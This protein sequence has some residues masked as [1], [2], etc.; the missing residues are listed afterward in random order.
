MSPT[1]KL[2]EE[3]VTRLAQWKKMLSRQRVMKKLPDEETAHTIQMLS[4]GTGIVSFRKNMKP[5]KP[6]T[7]HHGHQYDAAFYVLEG[8]GFEI[9][10][11]KRFE[12]EAGDM[13]FVRPGGCVHQHFN[14]DP[15][16]PARVLVFASLPMFHA[17][18]LAA[19][20]LVELSDEF[21]SDQEYKDQMLVREGAETNG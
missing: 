16:K 10:D 4:T 12:W 6:S 17:M 9:H 21:A 1:P 15:E 7:F 5:G 3:G 8:K 19:D 20:D 11:G 2:A 13:Y 14:A 18:N